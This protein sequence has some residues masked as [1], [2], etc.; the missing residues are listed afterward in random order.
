MVTVW[1]NLSL[2]TTLTSQTSSLAILLKSNVL[3]PKH[4]TPSQRR[5]HIDLQINS[6]L[7]EYTEFKTYSLR[8]QIIPNHH[9]S[10]YSHTT[11]RIS[12]TLPPCPEYIESQTYRTYKIPNTLSTNINYVESSANTLPSHIEYTEGL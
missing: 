12:N 1:I 11:H 4:A 8:L 2:T 7:T 3:N 5:L 6:L 10:V 9:H